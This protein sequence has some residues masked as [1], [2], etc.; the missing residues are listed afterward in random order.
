VRREGEKGSV[1]TLLEILLLCGSKLLECNCTA[2]VST[3]LEI[4][5]GERL[6]I[7]VWG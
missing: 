4:L 1:S 5:H 2:T 6:R 3:L 7:R